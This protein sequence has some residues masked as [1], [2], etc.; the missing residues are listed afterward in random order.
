MMNLLQLKNFLKEVTTRAR[1]ID[2]IP[3]TLSPK[4][5]LI[6]MSAHRKLYESLTHILDIAEGK[7]SVKDKKD[8]FYWLP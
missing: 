4:E 5:K 1:N 2:N 6:E 7:R 3:N 8:K